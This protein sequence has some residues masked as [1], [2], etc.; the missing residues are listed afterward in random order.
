MGDERDVGGWEGCWW[1]LTSML[2]D[3]ED[4]LLAGVF[5]QELEGFSEGQSSLKR[6]VRRFPGEDGSRTLSFAMP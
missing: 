2:R 4:E 5:I 1:I 3:L 6:V